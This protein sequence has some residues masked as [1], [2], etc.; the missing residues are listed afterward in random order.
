MTR[1]MTWILKWLKKRRWNKGMCFSRE[2]SWKWFQ[3][4]IQSKSKSAWVYGI[5]QQELVPTWFKSTKWL[6]M[7]TSKL[8]IGKS[9]S[10]TSPKSRPIHGTR[11]YKTSFTIAF[12]RP[13]WPTRWVGSIVKIRSVS[14][15]MT[16]RTTGLVHSKKWTKTKLI[17][18][19]TA[20]FK[21]ITYILRT[22][23]CFHST[24]DNRHH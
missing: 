18:H 3:L 6:L 1:V 19:I 11:C 9:S 24:R 5:L 2:K 7:K 15:R 22:Y 10:F 4:T 16:S 21:P 20:Q 13:C 14:I 8:R 23:R 12:H 17:S